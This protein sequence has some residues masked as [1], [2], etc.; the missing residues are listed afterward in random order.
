LILDTDALSA[1]VDGD[2]GIEPHIK[3]ARVMAIPVVVLGEYRF[4]VL[5]SKRRSRHEEWLRENLSLYRILRVDEETSEIYAD[6]RLE[7]KRAGT[8]IPSNDL[9]IAA[10][11]RQFGFPV[12]SRDLHFDLVKGLRRVGW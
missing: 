4:G 5:Q 3:S 7:L 10:L 6:L 1:V 2:P 8:P 9:W 11:S 12:L